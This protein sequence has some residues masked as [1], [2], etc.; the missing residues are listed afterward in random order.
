MSFNFKAATQAARKG[1]LVLFCQKNYYSSNYAVAV[2]IPDVQSNRSRLSQIGSEFAR[3]VTG[4]FIERDINQFAAKK[5]K[6]YRSILRIPDIMTQAR[7]VSGIKSIYFYAFFRYKARA[8]E[9]FQH[10]CQNFSVTIDDFYLNVNDIKDTIQVKGCAY[11]DEKGRYAN[12]SIH[13]IKK[14]QVY[15]DKDKI[16]Y[17][18]I[19]EQLS[20]TISPQI[21]NAYVSAIKGEE[22]KILRR[23]KKRPLNGIRLPEVCIWSYAFALPILD[24]ERKKM[25][26]TVYPSASKSSCINNP[27]SGRYAEWV[28]P[29]GSFRVL[30]SSDQNAVMDPNVDIYITM[31]T[32]GYTGGR[33]DVPLDLQWY[34][35]E[36][37][38]DRCGHIFIY[39]DEK[40][41]A[42]VAGYIRSIL[43]Y[44]DY[45][46]ILPGWIEIDDEFLRHKSMKPIKRLLLGK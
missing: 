46:I 35:S 32:G 10:I 8:E 19:M 39:H 42:A 38:V 45:Q 3:V 25:A 11:A 40:Y 33:Y 28:P 44:T 30:Q 21:I 6:N 2:E 14:L 1:H 5:G 23:L 7:D 27:S 37:G 16:D 20:Q 24:E 9:L 31:W 34:R 4:F 22:K 17:D 26:V 29:S 18:A 36:Y 43:D 15:W 12:M 41:Y 13:G